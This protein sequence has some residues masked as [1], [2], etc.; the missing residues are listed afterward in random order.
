VSYAPDSRDARRLNGGGINTIPEYR[1]GT[2]WVGAFDGLYR[3]DRR[4]G[5]F[6]RYTAREG[7]PSRYR[8][9]GFDPGWNEQ[10]RLRV[11]D[12]GRGIDKAAVASHETAGHFGLRGMTERTALLGGKLAVWSEVDG[13]TELELRLPANIVYVTIAKRSWWSRLLAKHPARAEG[14][15]S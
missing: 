4:S 2:L 15:A 9:E 7:L 11:R 3:Y 6:A 8:L 5:A 1:A 14:D 10:F 12:N 13:G